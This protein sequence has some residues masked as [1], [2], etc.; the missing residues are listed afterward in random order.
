MKRI[1]VLAAALL[2]AV[3]SWGKGKLAPDLSTDPKQ[4]VDVIIQY[5]V[6]PQQKHRDRISRRG[7]QVTDSVDLVKGIV[8][9]VPANALADLA[10][11]PDVAYVSPDRPL[12]PFLNYA[13]PAI[14]APRSSRVT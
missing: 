3:P 14:N 10:Q 9:H 13:A 1:L 11:D 2:V 4:T 7:G 5:K 12:H 6:A 8:A